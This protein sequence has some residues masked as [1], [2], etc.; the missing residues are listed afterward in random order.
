MEESQLADALDRIAYA[1]RQ[2]GNADAATPMG[3]MEALG[4]ELSESIRDI[5]GAV[6][7]TGAIQDGI[8]EGAKQLAKAIGDNFVS[9]NE[10]DRNME[11]ANVVDGL[12]EV[13]RAI[14][15]FAK[16]YA[17]AQGLDPTNPY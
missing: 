17:K 16:V 1:L 10:L 13:G 11:A 12:F 3:G 8:E 2:L 7:N 9:P 6:E 14:R 15:F 5:A 4:K